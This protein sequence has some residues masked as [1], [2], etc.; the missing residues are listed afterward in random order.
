MGVRRTV[1][2]PKLRFK[3]DE[4]TETYKAK[5]LDMDVWVSFFKNGK[6]RDVCCINAN[7]MLQSYPKRKIRR[8]R[9]VASP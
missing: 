1:D 6:V 9:E 7:G 4:A 5:F 8:K 2:H 3:Y